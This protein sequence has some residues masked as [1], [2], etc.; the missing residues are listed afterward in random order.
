MRAGGGGEEE[1]KSTDAHEGGAGGV[2]HLV[3]PEA[4][5]CHFPLFSHP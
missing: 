3:G 2:W 1:G 4:L 5:P